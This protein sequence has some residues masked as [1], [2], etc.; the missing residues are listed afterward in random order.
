MVLGRGRH[1]SMDGNDESATPEQTKKKIISG[2]KWA[3]LLVRL[4]GSAQDHFAVGPWDDIH[5]ATL[6][7]Y[8]RKI[9][10]KS[11][12]AKRAC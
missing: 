5:D 8:S 6:V 12:K 3:L 11:L 9:K 7:G 1:E 10:K 4:V 2:M